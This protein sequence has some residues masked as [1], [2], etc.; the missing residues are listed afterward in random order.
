MIRILQLSLPLLLLATGLLSAEGDSGVPYGESF[1]VPSTP[2]PTVGTVMADTSLHGIDVILTGTILDV[3]QKKGCWIVVSDGTS[4]MRVTFRDYSFFLPT[5]SFNRTVIIRG[6]VTVETIDE[7]TAKHYAEES[8]GED[9]DAIDGPQR[10][11][12][13][14]AGGV[15]VTGE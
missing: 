11:V 6:V 14:V 1:E 15:L 7:E 9:P 10:V 5:D 8:K 4:Q 2:L 3:C 13:M 12:T